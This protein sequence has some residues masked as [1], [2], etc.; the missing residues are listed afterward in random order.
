MNG[1]LERFMEAP[2]INKLG[3][4][5]FIILATGVAIYYIREIIIGYLIEKECEKKA[6]RKREREVQKKYFSDKQKQQKQTWI[7]LK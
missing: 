3:F 4:I 7:K 6:Y 5:T 2:L 1:I